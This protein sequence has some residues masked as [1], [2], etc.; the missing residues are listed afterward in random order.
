[1]AFVTEI[2]KVQKLTASN[3]NIS[4]C[5]VKRG[6]W[7]HFEFVRIPGREWCTLHDLRK[8]TERETEGWLWDVH[9]TTLRMSTDSEAEDWLSECAL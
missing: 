9:C 3:A 8:S 6:I 1:M 5:S 2:I 4:R 7:K